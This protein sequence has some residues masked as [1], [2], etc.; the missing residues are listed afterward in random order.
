VKDQLDLKKFLRKDY[1]DGYMQTQVRAGIAYQFQALR[2]KF[3]LNQNE[4][5]ERIGKPQSTVSRL[6]NVEYGRVSVQTLLDIASSLDV[7]LIVQF[8]SYP[9]FLRRTEDMTESSL[10]VDTVYES[11][12]K[13]DFA[14]ITSGA[15]SRSVNTY[16]KEPYQHAAESTSYARRLLD[17][18][19]RTSLVNSGSNSDLQSTRSDA[20]R[21]S[22]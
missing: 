2:K 22:A 10:Q 7:A 14:S 3:D 13:C 20:S 18:G 8:A 9:D 15:A 16:R 11:K 4:M 5:A 17:T 19:Q 21:L 6:E 1:R 12:T